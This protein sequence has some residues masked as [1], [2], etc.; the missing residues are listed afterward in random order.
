MAHAQRSGVTVRRRRSASDARLHIHP[1][2]NWLENS[3]A[4]HSILLY[5]RTVWSLWCQ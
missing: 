3:T 1:V 5:V 2:Q 4:C